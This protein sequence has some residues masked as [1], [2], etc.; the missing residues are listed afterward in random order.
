MRQQHSTGSHSRATR[1]HGDEAYAPPEQSDDSPSFTTDD[2]SATSRSSKQHGAPAPLLP[3]PPRLQSGVIRTQVSGS[4]SSV[5]SAERSAIDIL[6]QQ[7]AS[8]HR[9]AGGGASASAVGRAAQAGISSA[10]AAAVA[11]ARAPRGPIARPGRA[12]NPDHCPV[13]LEQFSSQFEFLQQQNDGDAVSAKSSESVRDQK[14]RSHIIKNTGDR[15]KMI[16]RI[17]SV[18]RG[19]VSDEQLIPLLLAL[20][21]ELIENVLAQHPTIHFHKWTQRMLA[22]HYDVDNEHIFDPIRELKRDLKTTRRTMKQMEN[23]FLVPDPDNPAQ[24][25]LDHRTLASYDKFSSRRQNLLKEIQAYHK[26][27]EENLTQ[28]L[29]ALVS[30][31]SHRSK[32]SARLVT[33]DPRLAAGNMIVGGDTMRSAGKSLATATGTAYDMYHLSGF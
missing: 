18:L 16:F 13:C 5:S 23:R 19:M 3:P 20:H 33:N 6:V 14:V 29:F 17:E 11:M 27:K 24:Q 15:Y 30:E 26:A 7:A 31:V 1:S 22:E 2:S 4:E 25:V 10:A 28:A 12:V 9:A 8:Q 21:K 32:D